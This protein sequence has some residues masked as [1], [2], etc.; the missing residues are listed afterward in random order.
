[1]TTY[2]L[3][4]ELFH[5]LEGLCEDVE[6][7][8][9][10]LCTEGKS[11]GSDLVHDASILEDCFAS[12]EYT[13]NLWHDNPNSCIGDQLGRNVALLKILFDCLTTDPRNSLSHDDIKADTSLHSLD[14]H[15]SH[16]RRIPVH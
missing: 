14:H 13:I 1:M 4:R 6:G 16:D 8:L 2:L 5:E 15:M 9:E 10:S 7:F 11:E 12:H 3:E